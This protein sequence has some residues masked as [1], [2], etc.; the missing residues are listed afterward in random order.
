VLVGTTI[1]CGVLVV[2]YRGWWHALT[3]PLWIAIL[4]GTVWVVF[5]WPY[6]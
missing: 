2:G 3:I 5:F 1:A 4:S 6:G